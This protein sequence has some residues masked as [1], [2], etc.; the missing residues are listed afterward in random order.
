NVGSGINASAQL[1]YGILDY[2]LHDKFD[3]AG[4]ES[5]TD[6]VK[7]LQNKI[8]PY[9]YVD[10]TNFQ[11]A[12][13]HLTGYGASYYSYLWSKVYAE[14]MFSV[15]EKKGIMDEK[16]GMRYRDIILSKGGSRDEY[17]MVKDFLGRD[18]NQDA[19]LKSLG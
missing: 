11:A 17:E 19:F 8:L 13:G 1:F 9:A 7:Q 16:T 6:I 15:F 2:T 12:F 4:T 5:T 14:D 3:P 18:P 10:D